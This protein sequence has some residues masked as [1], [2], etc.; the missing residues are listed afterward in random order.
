MCVNCLVLSHFLCSLS[1]SLLSLSLSLSLSPS[2][3][4]LYDYQPGLLDAQLL[5]AW[6]TV[7]HSAHTK[8]TYL[9]LDLCLGHIPRLFQVC[10]SCML[11][12]KPAIKETASDTMKVG[13][14]A[15][16]SLYL[17]LCVLACWQFMHPVNL[18]YSPVDRL[19]F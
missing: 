2:S 13:R 17:V 10:V 9:N 15:F 6:L 18:D 5:Q 19:T 16:F 3:Q 1:L 12:N 11:S 4:A 8:L 14:A 7:M